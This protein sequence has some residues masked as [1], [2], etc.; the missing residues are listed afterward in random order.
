MNTI[1]N[2]AKTLTIMFIVLLAMV[3]AFYAS[4]IAIPFLV[5][6]IGGIFIFNYLKYRAY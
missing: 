5:I 4:Y 1:I 2:I 6:T 3:V